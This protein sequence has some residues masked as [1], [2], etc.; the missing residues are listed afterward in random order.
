MKPLQQ[1]NYVFYATVI[2]LKIF[3]YPEVKNKKSMCFDVK[4]AESRYRESKRM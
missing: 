2:V 4:K 3:K 1:K